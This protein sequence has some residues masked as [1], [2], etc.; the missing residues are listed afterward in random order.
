[1]KN[2]MKYIILLF[3]LLGVGVNEAFSQSDSLLHYLRVAAQNN[4]AIKSDF[5]L[6]KASLEKIPQAGALADPQLEIGLF[7]TPMEVLDGKQI[8]DFE[9]MQ[10]FPW[11][12]TRK[13][14]RSEATE[15]A[16]MSF[17]KF[18]E[19]RDKLFLEV[20]SQWY[21]LSN[22]HQQLRNVNENRI[23]LVSLKELS[24]SRF[25][26]PAMGAASA[27]RS[28][29]TSASASQN[30]PAASGGMAGMGGSQA[31]AAPQATQQ[32]SSTGGGMGSSGNSMGSSSSIGMSDVLRVDLEINELDDQQ[33]A[34]RSEIRSGEA[35]FNAL[36]NRS[37]QQTI[38]VPDTIQQLAFAMD[39][40]LIME[41]ISKQNPMLGMISAEIQSYKSK[42]VMDK[43]MGL[44]MIGIG[45]QYSL[46]SRRMDMGI[47]TTS[48]NGKDMIMPMVSL[49]IPI[50]RKK[51]SAQ[52][53]ESRLM[54]LSAEEKYANTLNT[55]NAEYIRVK[56]AI[57]DAGRKVQLYQKQQELA[58]VTYN[59]AVSELVSGVGS[60]TSVI[61][62]QRQLLDYKLKLSQGI[63]TYNTTIAMLE[64]L[65][66]EFETE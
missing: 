51:Y 62:I 9:V 23:L 37:S 6:Y 40:A 43:K 65:L 15:M 31:A 29:Q 64:N 8:A 53:N 50:Y 60:L 7:L 19:S 63:L 49:S 14:A 20:K 66:S 48:M 11:F 59:L 3:V 57:A 55:L 1:M 16:R 41:T 34:I 47:P 35:K 44:P 38:S 12:G 36:L 10:M 42:L 21:A 2:R 4:P 22:L 56:Q 27:S 13:A 61:D 24:L 18:R 58:L 52:R 33:Q 45:L 46:L 32:M 39:N 28:S 17:E 5:L 30:S 54:I 26:S 25:S